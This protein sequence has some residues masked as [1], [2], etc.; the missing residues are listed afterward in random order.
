MSG[1]CGAERER[2]GE[3]VGTASS[4]HTRS[5]G[6]I[7]IHTGPA[8]AYSV[9]VREFVTYGAFIKYHA[10]LWGSARWALARNRCEVFSVIGHPSAE[11]VRALS[12]S[13]VSPESASEL[14]ET[15]VGSVGGKQYP[16]EKFFVILLGMKIH[17]REGSSVPQKLLERFQW[18]RENGLNGLEVVN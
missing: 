1:E 13:L 3:R 16:I 12:L 10:V 14:L 11:I 17:R 8:R 7:D 4:G 15:L 18:F 6:G 5:A 2:E 9:W